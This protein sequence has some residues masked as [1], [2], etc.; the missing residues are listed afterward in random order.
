M[1]SRAPSWRVHLA[2][3]AE[4]LA[5]TSVLPGQLRHLASGHGYETK[6]L[7]ADLTKKVR[8]KAS[9]LSRISDLF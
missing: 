9:E 3:P 6:R 4:G 1:W 7:R 8:Q 5:Q 2:W